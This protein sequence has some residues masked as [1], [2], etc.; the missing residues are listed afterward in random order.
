VDETTGTQYGP[1]PMTPV[2]QRGSGLGTRW[3]TAGW[4]E[5]V[6][7]ALIAFIGLAAFGILLVVLLNVTTPGPGLPTGTT[8][9]VGFGLFYLFDRVGQTATISGLSG[10]ASSALGGLTGAKVTFTLA[11]MGGTALTVLLLWVGGKAAG[12]AV[13]GSAL[14]RALGAAKI[15]IPYA[16][17]G[18]AGAFA[19]RWSSTLPA[20]TTPV[21]LA[22][23]PSYAAAIGRPLFLGIVA[24]F[25]GGY[26]SGTSSERAGER[27]AEPS[28]VEPS[29]AERSAIAAL[30]DG[31]MMMVVAL[32]AAFVGLLVLAVVK[33]HDT[34]SYLN[35][36]FN[37]GAGTG[38]LGIILTA[39]FIPN[40][41]AL[42]LFPSMGAC[43]S[44]KA[45][46]LSV[47]ALSWTHFP[48]A[49]ASS[50]AAGLTQGRVPDLPSPPGGYYL[51]ILVPVV[52]VLAGGFLA[53]R[54][55]SART[56]GESAMVGALAGVGY[57]I[58]AVLV[59]IL[60][61]IVLKASGSSGLLG[62]GASATAGPE[63]IAGGL[64]A[65]AWGVVGGTIGALIHGRSLPTTAPPAAAEPA[66]PSVGFVPPSTPP[67]TEAVAPTEP[68]PPPPGSVRPTEPPG[69]TEQ[70]PPA[71]RP[72]E[73]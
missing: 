36:I 18:L 65:L 47:C 13:G 53:A 59:A 39:L 24:G 25:A 12:K 51:F 20:G 61:D 21:R 26:R 28:R 70:G 52:A 4:A 16:V 49:P 9:R 6:L 63:P 3:L 32:A 66:A 2:R 45:S 19:G 68:V 1:G 54:R 38:I 17:F 48:A 14:A 43:I 73:P 69:P 46:V 34:S 40:M 58:I 71:E 41:S 56:R 60:A 35:G 8:F 50:A 11:V 42:V 44:A 55:S 29:R 23:H 67:P 64:I 22:V 37:S 31:W 30:R 62:A 5:V 27:A 15:G 33:P 72:P 7:W 10:S 57:A